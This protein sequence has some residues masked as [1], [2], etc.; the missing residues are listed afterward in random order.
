MSIQTT[1]KHAIRKNLHNKSDTLPQLKFSGKLF[2]SENLCHE[3]HQLAYKWKQ[4]NKAGKIYSTWFWNN[5]I[6]IKLGE[7][8]QPI[9]IHHIT[10]TEKFLDINT[11]DEFINNTSL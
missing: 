3:N 8:D 4:F 10:G 7:R 9:K 1:P 11:L 2:I 6:N 5:S